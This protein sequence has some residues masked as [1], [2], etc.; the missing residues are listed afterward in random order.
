[1]KK[2]ITKSLHFLYARYAPRGAYQ[3]FSQ[4]GED[5]IMASIL[6]KNKI[7]RVSYIDIG[8]HH[9][10]FGNNTYLFYRS[11]GQ[12]VLIE[13]NEYLCK[14]IKR[15]RPRDTVVCAG[16]GEQNGQAL[17]YS[18]KRSTR[19][20]FSKEQV[21]TWEKTSGDEATTEMRD[22]ISLDTIIEHHCKGQTPT[23]VSMDAEGYD[24]KILSGFSWK[25]RPLIFCIE[26]AGN[27]IIHSIMDKN[28]YTF[29]AQVFQNTIFTDTQQYQK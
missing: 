19:N 17:F 22:I 3:S 2:F 4:T 1:M 9:P 10:V 7:K 13:P 20:T 25:K 15:I 29:S 28:G 18:F 27:E 8:A 26:S 5:L 24:I 6:T 23:I 16:I 14:E 12:G 11:H 21:A